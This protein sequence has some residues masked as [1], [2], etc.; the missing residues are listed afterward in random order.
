MLPIDYS[1]LDR[2]VSYFVS[3]RNGIRGLFFTNKI[4]KCKDVLFKIYNIDC[5]VGFII[6][7]ICWYI[8]IYTFLFLQLILFCE[9]F[10]NILYFN[11]FPEVN[12]LTSCSYSEKILRELTH[13]RYRIYWRLK[14]SSPS[15][16]LLKVYAQSWKG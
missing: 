10:L 14:S 13:Y 5:F 4:K 16:Q 2:R 6:L 11:F 7:W 1:L 9:T 8:Y 3:F 12:V 15:S